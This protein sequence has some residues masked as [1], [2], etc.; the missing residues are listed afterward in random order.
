ML[1]RAPEA[2]QLRYLQSLQQIAGDRSSTI[3]FPLPGE[4]LGTLARA[5]RPPGA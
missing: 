1:G 4:L 3:V 2:M 5:A